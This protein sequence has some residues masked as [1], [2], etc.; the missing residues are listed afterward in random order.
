MKLKT[1]ATEKIKRRYIL[2]D[3]NDRNKVEKAVL[4]YIGL[5]GWA[6]AKPVFVE[7]RGTVLSVD[8]AWDLHVRAALE[9]EGIKVIRVSGTLAGLGR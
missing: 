3:S 4:D 2:V 9:L 8:R 5:L 6:K 7:S 1:R